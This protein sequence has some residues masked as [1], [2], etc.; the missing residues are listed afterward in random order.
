[1]SV[2][3][4][5]LGV[6]CIWRQGRLAGHCVTAGLHTAPLRPDVDQPDNITGGQK[7]DENR[8]D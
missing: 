3:L 8:E 1:M 7:G 2:I 6:R 4:L 5:S